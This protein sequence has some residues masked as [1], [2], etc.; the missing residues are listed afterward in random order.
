VSKRA[1]APLAHR[2]IRINNGSA[3]RAPLSRNTSFT[4]TVSKANRTRSPSLVA[5]KVD[6]VHLRSAAGAPLPSRP[7]LS[8][9]KTQLASSTTSIGTARDQEGSDLAWREALPR[10]G[11]AQKIERSD[12]PF[13]QPFNAEPA[14]PNRPN[15]DPSPAYQTRP[16]GPLATIPVA[17]WSQATHL[18]RCVCVADFE[19]AAHIRYATLPFLTLRKDEGIE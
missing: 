19:V 16:I 10:D 5:P 4:S 15:M 6:D 3:L 2:S 14:L 7:Y 12:H 17:N 13:N 11:Y 9:S 8:R 1:D 18:Y